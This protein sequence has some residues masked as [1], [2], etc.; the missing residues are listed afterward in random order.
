MDLGNGFAVWPRKSS[1][2]PAACETLNVGYPTNTKVCVCVEAVA[3]GKSER[4]AEKKSSAHSASLAAP[5]S[6]ASSLPRGPFKFDL[7]KMGERPERG[8]RGR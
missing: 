3:K 8:S 6:S 2:L 1:F 4:G 7:H 5:T